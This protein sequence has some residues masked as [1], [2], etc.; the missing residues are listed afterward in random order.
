MCMPNFYFDD[1]DDE[2]MDEDEKGEE[3]VYMT[4]MRALLKELENEDVDEEMMM[5]ELEDE[6]GDID[7]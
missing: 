6:A 4:D 1:L 5:P 3:T 7:F 2:E